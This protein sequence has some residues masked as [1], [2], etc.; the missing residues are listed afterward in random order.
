MLQFYTKLEQRLIGAIQ[1]EDVPLLKELLPRAEADWP[2]QLGELIAWGYRIIDWTEDRRET[3]ESKEHKIR[4]DYKPKGDYLDETGKVLFKRQILGDESYQPN[5]LRNTKPKHKSMLKSDS[6]SFCT[7]SDFV[8]TSSESVLCTTVSD[9]VEDC[10]RC[11]FKRILIDSTTGFL[12][13]KKCDLKVRPP[14]L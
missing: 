12:Y 13:C 3:E 2:S 10:C 5:L 7:D 1:T 4:K 9:L 11:Q 6:D 14:T 8:D